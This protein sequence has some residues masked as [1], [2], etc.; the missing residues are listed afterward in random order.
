MS[1]ATETRG[2]DDFGSMR[3]GTVR[4]LHVTNRISIA[5]VSI[6]MLARSLFFLLIPSMYSWFISPIYLMVLE[7]VPCNTPV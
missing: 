3:S 7:D 2:V 6:F 4:C 5:A 1:T